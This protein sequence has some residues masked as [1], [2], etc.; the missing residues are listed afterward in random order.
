MTGLERLNPPCGQVRVGRSEHRPLGLHH[1]RP[2][3]WAGPAG[4]G[5]GGKPPTPFP[6][7]P[8]QS[9]T[10]LRVAETGICCRHYSHLPISNLL[11]AENETGSGRGDLGSTRYTSCA[12]EDTACDLPGP[13][14]GHQAGSGI[15]V[16]LQNHIFLDL[17][18]QGRSDY[19]WKKNSWAGKDI[20]SFKQ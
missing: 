8:H 14:R 18:S 10:P 5:Q 19:S 7:T 12:Y 1:Q 15:R 9:H 11:F 2:C 4:S 13:C 20:H 17:K 3:P 16:Y 6:S